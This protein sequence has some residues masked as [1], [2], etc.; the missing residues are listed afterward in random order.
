MIVKDIY[1]ID[2]KVSKL[3]ALLYIVV[4][5]AP[6]QRMLTGSSY[7]GIILLHHLTSW[8]FLFFP[9]WTVQKIFI[10][11]CWNPQIVQM[12]DIH[13][14][15]PLTH[16]RMLKGIKIWLQ[17][18]SLRYGDD[19][20]LIVPL[21]RT[22]FGSAGRLGFWINTGLGKVM[23]SVHWRTDRKTDMQSDGEEIN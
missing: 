13:H 3:P 6:D 1:M 11:F 20:S 18:G 14:T 21:A 2:L 15:W 8:P 7:S 16:D 12:A 17:N 22:A 23:E 4:N 19:D 10:F 9:L 5:I